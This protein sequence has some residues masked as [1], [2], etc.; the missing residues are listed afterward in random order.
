MTTADRKFQV[1]ITHHPGHFV[2]D[3]DEAE[4]FFDQVFRR[5]SISIDEVLARVAY[6]NPDFPHTYAAYTL[7]GDVFFDSIDPERLVFGGKNFAYLRHSVPH[8]ETL[9]WY[10]EGHTEAY[11]ALRS[12]G[13]TLVNSLGEV[14][15]GAMP[16]GPNDPAPFFT[17]GEETGLIYDFYPAMVFPCD[18]RTEPG[19]V[20]PPPSDNDPLGIEYCSHHTFLTDQP[21]RAVTLLVDVLGGEALHEGR[22]ELISATSTYVRLGDST[23]EF[24]VPD[25]GSPAYEDWVADAPND[26]YHSITWKVA[27]LDRAESHLEAQGVRTTTRS[28]HGFVTDPATSL[29]IPWGFSDVLVPGDPRATG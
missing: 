8:L 4:R 25:A 2:P 5:P 15:T 6:V 19:W 7:I 12:R 27:D 9:G 23:L 3:L 17:I 1:S 20:V 10:V 26:T 14:Q 16:T 21:E 13:Y 28:A 11:R 24:G 22:N 18:P 29:G